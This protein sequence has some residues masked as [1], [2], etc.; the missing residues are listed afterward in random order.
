VLAKIGAQRSSLLSEAKLKTLAD[1]KNLNDFAGQL[2]D[3]PYQEQIAKITLPLT[4]RK[5]ERAFNENLIETYQKIIKYSPK[6]AREYLSLY[7][8]RF[9]VENVKMLVKATF[10]NTSPEQKLAK[11]YPFV[12]C[13]IE[14]PV[15]LEDAAKATDLTHLVGVFKK[16]A[17]WCPLNTGLASYN[18]SGSTTCLEFFLDVFFYEHLYEVF[19]RLPKKEKPYARLYASLDNDG[20]VLFSLLRGKNLNYDSNWLRLAVPQNY[21]KLTKKQVEA[22]TSAISFE[23]AYKIVLTT[24]YAKYFVKEDNPEDTL[25]KAEKAFKKTIIEH[26]NASKICKIFNIGTPLAYM[27]MK[28]TE[29]YNLRAL[30]LGIDG[31]M[32]PDA[33]RAQLF[34]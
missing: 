15:L 30:A 1:S 4:G 14:K 33:I 5:L 21:F 18:E 6:A 19:E 13:H 2:R 11:L 16:T 26:A 31:D 8:L 10:A 12:G 32:K 7:L 22:V 9:E 23:A 20:F 24:E 29:V 34:T 27:T 28:E 3:T 25:A 17:Y